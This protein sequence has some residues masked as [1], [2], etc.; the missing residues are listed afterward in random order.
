MACVFN[1]IELLDTTGMASA[2]A[3]Y[4]RFQLLDATE[5]SILPVPDES[6]YFPETIP[7]STRPEIVRPPGPASLTR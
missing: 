4:P 3:G 5:F 7:M 2:S 1:R 6:A